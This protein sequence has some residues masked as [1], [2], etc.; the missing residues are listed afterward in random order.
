M[1]QTEKEM[2]MREISELEQRITAAQEKAQEDLAKQEE[3]LLAPHGGA[4]QQGHQ[5]CGQ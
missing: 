4:H 3:E 5:R 1:T 2:A